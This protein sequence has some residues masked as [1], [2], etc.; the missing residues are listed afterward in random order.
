MSLDQVSAQESELRNIVQSKAKGEHVATSCDSWTSLTGHTFMGVTHRWIDREWQLHNV[1]GSFHK[2]TGSTKAVIL[3]QQLP[4]IFSPFNM[5]NLTTDCESTM[6]KTG[7]CFE[8]IYTY[9]HIYMTPDT[10]DHYV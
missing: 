6:V 10:R 9:I 5:W 1:L 8:Y 3:A 7:N 2:H 4:K